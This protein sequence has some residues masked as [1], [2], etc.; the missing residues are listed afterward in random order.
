MTDPCGSYDS[1]LLCP[2]GQAGELALHEAIQDGWEPLVSWACEEGIQHIALR[3]PDPLDN[4]VQRV[5]FE[6]DW[7]VRRKMI[8]GAQIR[9]NEILANES[10]L[11]ET[12][13][14]TETT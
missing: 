2:W 14:E 7:R 4:L 6:Q 10:R 1:M 12:S 8:E 9:L 13:D 11:T 3:R 5:I